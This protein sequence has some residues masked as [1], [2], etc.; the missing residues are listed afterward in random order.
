M[1]VCS[2]YARSEGMAEGMAQG[3][4]KVYVEFKTQSEDVTG[5]GR[6]GTMKLGES[7]LH[8]K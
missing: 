4:L 1:P 6:M 7:G 3:R 2:S 5:A 8:L